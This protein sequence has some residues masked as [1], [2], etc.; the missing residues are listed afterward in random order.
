M[1]KSNREGIELLYNEPQESKFDLR[2]IEKRIE[3]KFLT[4]QEKEAFLK[5]LPEEKEYEF[6]SAE[7]LDADNGESN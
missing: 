4:R 3:H 6:T 7:A 2:L 5:S 1:S